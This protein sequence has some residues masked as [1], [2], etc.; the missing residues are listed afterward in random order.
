M[1]DR[2]EQSASIR[3]MQAQGLEHFATLTKIASVK[4]FVDEEYRLWRQESDCEQG[5]FPLA[6]RKRSE[7]RVEE[8]RQFEPIDDVGIQVFHAAIKTQHELQYPPE[9]LFRPGRD[10]VGN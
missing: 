7:F 1:V 3:A 4:R 10:S 5:P 6:F 9:R 2:K 8:G